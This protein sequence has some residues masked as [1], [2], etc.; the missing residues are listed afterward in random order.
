MC[1]L[2]VDADRSRIGVASFIASGQLCKKQYVVN[3]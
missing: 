1:S 3:E 2:H